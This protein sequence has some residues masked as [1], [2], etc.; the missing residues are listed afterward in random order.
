MNVVTKLLEVLQYFDY[1][2]SKIELFELWLEKDKSVSKE[3][4]IEK[5]SEAL[6]RT[7][8]N[9]V[10]LAIET[11]F[12]SSPEETDSLALDCDH[13]LI[14]TDSFRWNDVIQ[15]DVI[16]SSDQKNELK[17]QFRHIGVQDYKDIYEL[18]QQKDFEWLPFEVKHAFKSN[19]GALKYE[20]EDIVFYLKKIIWN[21]LFP[22]SIDF[23]KLDLL[24]KESLIILEKE[25]LNQ[26]WVDMGRIVQTLKNK[27]EDLDLFEL[28]QVN[29][30][31][32]IQH[33]N[34][35]RNPFTLGFKRIGSI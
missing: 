13:L 33:K 2:L 17:D 16:L 18:I 20:N 19:F 5:L 27:Y 31:E 30:G 22:D 24:K 10:Q 1:G 15:P 34:H 32:N 26:G 3:L 7:D 6:K 23:Q 29:W 8:F 35:Y 25:P 12:V 11:K 21:Y 4:I 14:F 9:W 28:T